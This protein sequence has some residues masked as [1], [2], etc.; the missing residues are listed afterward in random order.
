[1]IAER[2]HDNAC[3][4]RLRVAAYVGFVLYYCYYWV[5]HKKTSPFPKRHV[6]SLA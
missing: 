5:A 3:C 2:L 6:K 1:M 4:M